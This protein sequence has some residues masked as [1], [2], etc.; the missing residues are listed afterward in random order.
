MPQPA[1]IAPKKRSY[2]LLV[3]LLFGF[4]LLLLIAAQLLFDIFD[5][6]TPP[7]IS[8]TESRPQIAASPTNT[9]TAGPTVTPSSYN[10]NGL[11]LAQTTWEQTHTRTADSIFGDIAGIYDDL[12]DVLFIDGIIVRLEI[13]WDTDN[14]QTPDQVESIAQSLLPNDSQFTETYSPDGRPE[15]TVHLYNSASLAHRLDTASD[16]WFS[17]EPGTFIFQYN[18]FDGAVTRMII[19]TGNN[20]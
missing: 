3:G 13:Q 7:A 1:A 17:A 10:S 8:Q 14:A 16:W 20:P 6:D 4:C 15:T 5:T 9:P 18:T 12:Y 11:G 2:K 19:S